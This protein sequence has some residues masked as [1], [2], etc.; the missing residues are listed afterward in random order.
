MASSTSLPGA[1]IGKYRILTHIATGGMGTVY[2]AR[3][4]ML[5]RVVALKVLSPDLASNPIL[6]ERFSREAR[7][8]I[9]LD[10]KY[11]VKLYESGEAGGLYYLA[12]EYIHGI[13][14]NTYIRDKGQLDP[15][16]ARRIVIQAAKALRHAG[17]QGIV[18]RDIKPSNF[19]LADEGGG[20]C[21]VKLTDLG[22]SRLHDEEHFRVTRDGTTVGTVDYMSPEQAKD[23]AAADIRSDMYSL[24]CTLYHMLAGQPPFSEGGLGERLYKHLCAE[25]P[26][27]R[28]FNPKVPVGLWTVLRRML[29]KHPEDRFQ[30][31][32][33]LIEALRSLSPDAQAPTEFREPDSEAESLAV[34]SPVPEQPRREQPRK[35]RKTRRRQATTTAD[36]PTVPDEPPDPLGITPEQR[37]AAA[38]QY[39]HA[40]EVVR[41]SGDPAYAQQLLLSCC[42]LDPTNILYRRMLREVSRSQAASKKAGWFGSLGN[43]TARGP[44]RAARSAGDHRKVLEHGEELLC[45]NPTDAATHLDMAAAA[46]GLGLPGL[47]VWLLEDACQQ[48]PEAVHLFRALAQLYERQK[49]FPQAITVWEKVRELAPEDRDASTKILDLAASDTI[50]RGNFQT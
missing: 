22:L 12:L 39:T 11:I 10:N 28:D 50:A 37:Q 1:R 2:K 3:D 41:S 8:A 36:P 42:K 47:A 16:E 18:H 29:A 31:P 7:A 45:R 14:L 21:R 46:E 17:E 25:P 9:R 4:E 44:L 32:A 24:G 35:S 43:L 49:R 48:L 5:G 23:S 19:L 27:V 20:R 40:T 30:T 38:G 26:D 34:R 15:E 6:L 13:D 33:E